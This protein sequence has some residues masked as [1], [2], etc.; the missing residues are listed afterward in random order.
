MK[1]DQFIAK[2]RVRLNDPIRTI[3]ADQLW[4]TDELVDYT[5]EAIN[6][7]ARVVEYFKD[8]TTQDICRV[9]ITS[10][11]N[12]APIDN[13]IIRIRRAKLALSHTPLGVVDCRNEDIQFPNWDSATNQGN[14]RMMMLGEELDK[15]FF[16]RTPIDDDTM[17]LAVVRYPLCVAES[18]KEIP[19][20]DR[21]CLKLLTGARAEAYK[22]QDAD[23]MD[24][25]KALKFDAEFQK[26]LLKIKHEIGKKTRHPRQVQYRDCG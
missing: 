25:G 4:K 15:V 24:A 9:Q 23:T 6:E 10:G 12:W 3:A 7:F 26:E 1:V 17:N 8:S 22:K 13:R 5:N 11:Q 21:Y 14:P 2:L 16:D 20:P 18:G 19:I